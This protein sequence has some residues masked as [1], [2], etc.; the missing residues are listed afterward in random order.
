MGIVNF[1]ENQELTIERES[2]NQESERAKR[3]RTNYMK[4]WKPVNKNESK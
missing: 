4:C 1:E 2:K 3:T